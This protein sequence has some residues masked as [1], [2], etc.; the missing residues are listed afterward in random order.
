MIDLGRGDIKGIP[1]Q[2]EFQQMA[3]KRGSSE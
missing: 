1:V 2:G 3:Y